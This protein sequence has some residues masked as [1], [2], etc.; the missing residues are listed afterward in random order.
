MPEYEQAL[1]TYI[2]DGGEGALHR[3]YSI[4]RDA[5]S[6][7]LSQLVSLHGEALAQMTRQRRLSAADLASIID[8]SNLF[9]EEALAPFE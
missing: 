1:R 6:G 9:L 7:G 3:A 8:R 5:I 2:S 4:G